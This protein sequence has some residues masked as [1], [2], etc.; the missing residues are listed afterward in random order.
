MSTADSVLLSEVANAVRDIYQQILRPDASDKELLRIS[1]VVTLLIGLAALSVTYLVPTIIDLVLISY[2][3]KVC[4][5]LI[6]VVG[7]LLWK[8]ELSWERGPRLPW[9]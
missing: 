7:G 9:V 4:G 8:K 1:T 6:P 5:G 3:I 2:A